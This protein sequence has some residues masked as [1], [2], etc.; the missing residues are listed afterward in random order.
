[1]PGAAIAAAIL[2]AGYSSPTHMRLPV[3]GWQPQREGKEMKA[4]VCL[5]GV[6]ITVV[7]LVQGV[8]SVVSHQASASAFST[9]MRA[10]EAGHT[11]SDEPSVDKIYSPTG[12]MDSVTVS[13]PTAGIVQ[14]D[15]TF[16]AT[17]RPVT[18]AQPITYVWQATGQKVMTHTRCLTDTV[19]FAWSTA[20]TQA[21]TVTAT[22]RYNRVAGV[23]SIALT[24]GF[25]PLISVTVNGPSVGFVQS[26]YTF[27]ATVS[28]VTATRPI[29][30][31]WQATG[32]Q[33]AVTITNA[34]SHTVTYVWSET[35]TQTIVV[36]ATNDGRPVTGVHSISIGRRQV[37]LPL[38]LRDW[39]PIPATPKLSHIDNADIDGSYD[40]PWSA[41]S[42]AESYV[43]EEA[44]DRLFTVTT[45]VYTGTSTSHL[46]SGQTDG[47]Y[48][49]R[50]KACNCWGCSSWSNVEGVG[51]W[52][53]YDPEYDD[54]NDVCSRA[55]GPLVSGRRYHGYPNDTWDCFKFHQDSDGDIEVELADHVGR[56]VYLWLL[57]ENMNP[58]G[59]DD[60]SPFRIQYAGPEGQYYVCIYTGSGYTTTT[61]YALTVTF[62]QAQIGAGAGW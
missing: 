39:P 34:L 48:Y 58:V 19:T 25:S 33:D 18:A 52:Y 9:T 17:V 11:G 43:V 49:Y 56:R 6:A 44:T 36:T 35:G 7:L 32:Q 23:Y 55:N 59:I 61:P 8:V 30:Y 16:T 37:N 13:G 12:Y 60:S 24:G 45:Q 51:A 21:I 40:V 4:W 31:A 20:G 1:V 10:F 46:I 38:V 2:S 57:D 62:H 15:Y 50:V 14:T 54:S 3:Q 53:E 29:T 26:P 22:N 5:L 41:A 27:V 28:P 42:R 47:W